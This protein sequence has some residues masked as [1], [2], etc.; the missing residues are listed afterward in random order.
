VRTII[1]G[2]VGTDAD[3]GVALL[4]ALAGITTATATNPWLLKIEPGIY[5]LGASSLSM[6]SYVDIE[7]SGETVTTIRSASASA[8]IAGASSSEIRSLTV[9]NV[10]GNTYSYAFQTCFDMSVRDTTIRALNGATMTRAARV[11]CDSSPTFSRVTIIASGGGTTLALD[12]YSGTPRVE[13]SR[14]LAVGATDYN[15]GLMVRGGTVLR[16]E[17]R[18]EGKGLEVVVLDGGSTFAQGL[19]VVGV[20]EAGSG[21]SG[22]RLSATGGVGSPTATLEDSSIVMSGPG[23]SNGVTTYLDGG[24]CNIRRTTVVAGTGIYTSSGTG[25]FFVDASTIVGSSKTIDLAV[26]TTAFIG[27]SQLSGGPVSGSVTCVGVYDESYTSPG[28]S[29]CPS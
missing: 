19:R 6:K 10:G 25:S 16:T 13:D 14:V 26:G 29:T 23:W 22:L 7:G 21:G 9:E 18:A 17:V 4:A 2:P 15:Q 8:T 24:T 11:T 1:V 28:Y 12:A 5:D 27:A 20:T 3:N